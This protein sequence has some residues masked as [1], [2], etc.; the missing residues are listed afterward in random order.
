MPCSTG[1]KSPIA[2]RAIGTRDT[3]HVILSTDLKAPPHLAHSSYRRH[4]WLAIDAICWSRQHH[5]P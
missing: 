2:M 4:Q 3:R 5:A 1:K